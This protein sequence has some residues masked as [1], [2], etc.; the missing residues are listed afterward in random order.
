M[1]LLFCCC[2]CGAL[3]WLF[4]RSLLKVVDA[5]VVVTLFPCCLFMVIVI[6]CCGW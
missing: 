2:L 5:D 1:F 6:V 3:L 4:L